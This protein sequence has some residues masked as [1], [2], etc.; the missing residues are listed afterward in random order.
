MSYNDWRDDPGLKSHTEYKKRFAYFPVKCSDGTSV[1]FKKYYSKYKSW[2]MSHG[3]D[4]FE[5]DEYYLHTDFIEH[6]TEAEY[7]VRKLSENL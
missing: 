3:V 4:L 7:I 5:G 6:I 1:W 2:G